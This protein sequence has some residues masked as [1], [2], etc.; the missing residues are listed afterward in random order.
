MSDPT[1]AE[2]EDPIL[3]KDQAEDRAPTPGSPWVAAWALAIPAFHVPDFIAGSPSIARMGVISLAT[4]LAAWLLYRL[5]GPPARKLPALPNAALWAGLGAYFLFFAVISC[6]LA[7]TFAIDLAKDGAY[8]DQCLWNT[9]NGGGF[10]RASILQDHYYDPPLTNHFGLHMSPMMVALLAPYCLHQSFET[11]LLLRNLT[12]VATGIAVYL[13]ARDDLGRR[14]GAVI[15]AVYLLTPNTMA[16]HQ[17]A[18]Y[19]LA[20]GVPFL[21][22]A[23]VAYRR[24]RLWSCLALLLGACLCRED[25]ALTVTGFGLL[26][27]L[28]RRRWYWVA[29][30]VVLGLAW[31]VVASA[32]MKLFGRASGQAVL[33]WY[34]GFGSS[35]GEIVKRMITDPGYTLSVLF[36]PEKLLYLW[37]M[38][39][40]GVLVGVASPAAALALPQLGV[41]LLATLPGSPTIDPERHYSALVTLGVILSLSRVMARARARNERW[42]AVLGVLALLVTISA[43]TEVFSTKLLRSLRGNETTLALAA[44]A[45]LIPRD[46][47]VVAP[48]RMLHKLSARRWAAAVNWQQNAPRIKNP[49]YVIYGVG[50][51]MAY[52][53]PGT[54][55]R[56]LRE[57]ARVARNPHYR[58]V[59]RRAGVE[60]YRRRA[61][62]S[63]K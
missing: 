54:R 63:K 45:R 40:G 4:G 6:R 30:P 22:F 21:A 44:A 39:R 9:L 47:S 10:L 35:G 13:A 27:L 49:D 51:A 2:I 55:K 18:T 26:A 16:Q 61:T 38:V 46:A 23:Y 50:P 41:N 14:W 34:G 56:Y 53:L 11:V 12:I 48:A 20:Y 32:A 19:M 42:G 5:A 1:P 43:C 15:A 36:A 17:A 31:F 8:F 58:L 25:L 28:D 52:T 57:R 59:F 7:A 62:T 60:V 33:G 3:S 29:V 37:K 24:E